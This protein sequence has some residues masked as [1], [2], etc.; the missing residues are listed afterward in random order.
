MIYQQPDF[1]GNVR[2]TRIKFISD[3]YR[4]ARRRLECSRITRE[5]IWHEFVL[6]QIG[7]VKRANV[8]LFPPHNSR[9]RIK[10]RNEIGYYYVGR[11]I[12]VRTSPNSARVTHRNPS[13]CLIPVGFYME[14]PVQSQLNSFYSTRIYMRSYADCRRRAAPLALFTYDKFPPNWSN[15]E[16]LGHWNFNLCFTHFSVILIHEMNSSSYR[17]SFV[18]ISSLYVK[19]ASMCSFFLGNYKLEA[20]IQ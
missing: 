19:Y 16:Q 6:R 5:P 20:W 18:R 10:L 1:Q 2:L 4:G 15:M 13:S 14:I 12:E 11:I 7:I 17:K 9:A 3:A 8:T